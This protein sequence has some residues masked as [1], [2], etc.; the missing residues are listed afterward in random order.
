MLRKLMKH[1]FR[2]TGM[3]ML[4]L[5]GIVLVMALGANISIRVMTNASSRILNILGTLLVMAFGMAIVGVCVMSMVVM[6]RRFYKNLLRDEGYLMMTLPVSVH[7]QIWSKLIV[8]TVWFVLT[9]VVVGVACLVMAADVGVIRDLVRAFHGLFLDI[10]RNISA[11]YAINGTA[12]AVELLALCFFGCCAVCLHF[13]AALAIGHSFTNHKMA[14]SVVCFFGISFAVQFL[15]GLGIVALDNGWVYQL[16]TGWTDHL[17]AMAAIHATMLSLTFGEVVYS[18]VFY[19][20]TVF[21]LK[22][23]LNLE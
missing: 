14:W 13:Y 18:A 2:A 19:F 12:V 17:S 22:R 23:K 6:V 11:Y 16:L 10:Y 5:F 4:P 7:Q 1:E 8:S 15:G 3:I 20:L 21:F 9:A